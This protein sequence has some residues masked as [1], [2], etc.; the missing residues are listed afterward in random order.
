[1]ET[2]PAKW[3]RRDSVRR[4]CGG[5]GLVALA[6]LS[7]WNVVDTVGRVPVPPLVASVGEPDAVVAMERRLGRL[8]F[9]LERRGLR[10]PIGYVGDRPG[11]G[12]LDG[13]Q[14][15]ADFFQAQ[16]VLVPVVLDLSV[17]RRE[18]AVANLRA[19]SPLTRVPAGFA[20]VEDFGG[21]VFL[22]RKA[23]P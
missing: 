5:A 10:G 9:T 6:G 11:T 20:V 3:W 7:G 19:A 4:A 21:G 18:W 13:P 16:F 8:R 23:A 17:E 14:T 12:V 22:L 1:M 15:V 2:G